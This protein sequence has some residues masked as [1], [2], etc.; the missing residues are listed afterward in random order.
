[1]VYLHLPSESVNR[2]GFKVTVALSQELLDTKS[3]A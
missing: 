2:G 3:L 1:M